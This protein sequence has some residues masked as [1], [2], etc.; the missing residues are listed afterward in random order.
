MARQSK[1]LN[2]KNIRK[3]LVEVVASYAI[4]ASIDTI[5]IVQKIVVTILL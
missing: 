1:K 5:L 2:T 3:S 4:F